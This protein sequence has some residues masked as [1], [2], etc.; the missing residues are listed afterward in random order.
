MRSDETTNT[1]ID[2]LLGILGY[3]FHCFSTISILQLF[4]IKKTGV[5]SSG[6]TYDAQPRIISKKMTTQ[7]KTLFSSLPCEIYLHILSFIVDDELSNASLRNS[8]V[9]TIATFQSLNKKINNN[10]QMQQFFN[11]FWWKVYEKYF[12]N[13]SELDSKEKEELN[14]LRLKMIKNGKLKRKILLTKY[15][16]FSIMKPVYN[17]NQPKHSIN[18]I[19][20]VV[21]GEGGVGKSAITVRF[22][23]DIFVEEYDPTFEDTY[24]KMI[25]VDEKSVLLDILDTG[26]F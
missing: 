4:C 15:I 19:K 20:V 11:E 25:M 22:V 23:Q 2:R 21:I 12:G 10:F 5:L 1:K 16:K 3:Q 8:Q 7:Q 13:S 26:K 6:R 14:K 17:P 24:R 18:E 9:T